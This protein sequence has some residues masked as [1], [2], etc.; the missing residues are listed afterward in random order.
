M[1]HHPNIADPSLDETDVARLFSG[2]ALDGDRL[3]KV[4]G[5]L[6]AAASDPESGQAVALA[7]ANHLVETFSRDGQSPIGYGVLRHMNAM[8]AATVLPFV[9][10]LDFV[11]GS[12][13]PDAVAAGV[14]LA[15]VGLMSAAGQHDDAV[16]MMTQIHLSDT[17]CLDY[18]HALFVAQRK[19]RGLSDDLA[20][21]FCPVPFERFDVGMGG[22]VSLC[23]GMLLRKYPGNV[24]QQ[25]GLDIW[26]GMES[27]DVRQSIHDGSYRYCDKLRCRKFETGLI[28]LAKPDEQIL[29]ETRPFRDAA[30]EG[31]SIDAEM[32]G[33]ARS[34]A[35][36][37]PVGPRMVNLSF[38]Q[39]CNLSCPSCRTDIIAAKPAERDQMLRMAE[40][41]IMP[42]LHNT[43]LLVVT[44]SGDPFASKTF[45]HILRSID[46]ATHPELELKIMTNGVLFTPAEWD[47]IAHLWGRIRSVTI[48][49][50]AAKPET[51][52]IVRRGGDWERLQANLR[53]LGGLRRDGAFRELRLAFVV[54]AE[55]WREIPAFI[56]MGR[57]VGASVVH[58]G[59]IEN[60]GTF[61]P[62]V[63]ERQAVHYPTHPDHEAL[64][65][66]LASHD[67]TDRYAEFGL[68]E[69]LMNKDALLAAQ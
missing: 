21:Q 20:G 1:E 39:T 9:T 16:A 17:D 57:D 56:A 48:S 45:R 24:N 32:L 58:F 2:S 7:F 62:D 5:V 23:C 47:K 61:S 53:F 18:S 55:N 66:L 28:D 3:A 49:I 30:N 12:D 63:F 22:W 42:V 13:N 46:P 50:D 15:A 4:L 41:R 14:V 51:Y 25:S 34:H 60:W 6:D 29:E 59:P 31:R 19:Q 37:L 40:E 69:A 36:T 68:L 27:R 67:P 65:A 54:Q 11:S 43:R 38:D 64:R 8:A 33:Y 10:D 35:T 44:G 26:N 52:A